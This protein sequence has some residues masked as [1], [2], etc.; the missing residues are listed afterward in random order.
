MIGNEASKE[1]HAEGTNL[2]NLN[3]EALRVDTVE[4]FASLWDLTEVATTQLAYLKTISL[5]VDMT[6]DVAGVASVTEAAFKV[7][8]A[9]RPVDTKLVYISTNEGYVLKLDARVVGAEEATLTLGGAV[10]PVDAG[11]TTGARRRRLA[12]GGADGDVQ[13]LSREE[14]V[15]TLPES[16]IV[17]DI[18]KCI[19]VIHGRTFVII[20]SLILSIF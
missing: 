10:Y 8:G 4:S 20:S 9:F 17:D 5:K 16:D 6:S 1:S 19:F 3:H 2:V 13:L 12:A 18:S 7:S 15:D 14:F 11:E